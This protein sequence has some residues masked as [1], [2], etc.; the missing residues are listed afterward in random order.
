MSKALLV[1]AKAGRGSKWFNPKSE[2][3]DAFQQLGPLC[4]VSNILGKTFMTG[5]SFLPSITYPTRLE[6]LIGMSEFL[7]R[8]KYGAKL[9]MP[10]G[11]VLFLVLLA[12]CRPA[13]FL[14]LRNEAGETVYAQ[15]SKRGDVAIPHNSD[16]FLNILGRHLSVRM[17][18]K[19]SFDLSRV[20]SEHVHTTRMRLVVYAVLTNE[21]LFLAKKSRDGKFQRIEPQPIGFPLKG[22]PLP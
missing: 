11:A 7:M 19:R 15:D 10:F 16:T 1:L 18:E 14:E 2:Q 22:Q 9:L 20:P 3:D 4:L 13:L 5:I 17:P 8:T 12:G 6:S 21:G